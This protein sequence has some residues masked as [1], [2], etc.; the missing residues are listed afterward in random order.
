MKERKILSLLCKCFKFYIHKSK[1]KVGKAFIFYSK[2][3]MLYDC[4]MLL[5][6]IVNVAMEIPCLSGSCRECKIGISRRV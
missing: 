1:T 4:G 5:D 6:N 3:D 2:R